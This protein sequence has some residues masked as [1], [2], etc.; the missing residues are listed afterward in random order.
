MHLFQ[1][2]AKMNAATDYAVGMG[3]AHAMSVLK[4]PLVIY[5]L[6]LVRNFSTSIVFLISNH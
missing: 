4:G 2:N 1:T 5:L 3:L 6:N